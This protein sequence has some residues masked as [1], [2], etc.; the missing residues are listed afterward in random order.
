MFSFRFVV[1]LLY[2]VSEVIVRISIFVILF[3]SIYAY[4]FIPLAVELLTR[5]P[6]A[7]KKNNRKINVNWVITTFLF[8]GSDAY[9]GPDIG[10]GLRK[11]DLE[12]MSDFAPKTMDPAIVTALGFAI[13]TIYHFMALV[14]FNTLA[15]PSL[16][17]LR[18]LLA[19]RN[20]T[21]IS[22]VLVVPK[23]LLAM[24]ITCWEVDEVVSKQVVS[25]SKESKVPSNVNANVN[26]NANAAPIPLS[27]SSLAPSAT[28]QGVAFTQ[29]S[30]NT[31]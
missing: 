29:V 9:E 2:Y 7:F 12:K 17:T 26:A 15:T 18:L 11:N 30:I 24:F 6:V 21:I 28:G 8:F 27:S 10:F 19:T 20:M 23:V 4:A 22:C 13:T 5:A 3:V 16:D 25:T 14:I 31:V 1:H